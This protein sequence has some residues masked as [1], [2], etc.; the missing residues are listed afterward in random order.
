AS[1]LSG[2]VRHRGTGLSLDQE[3]CGDCPRGWEQ[4]ER[5]VALA[6]LTVV[7]LLVYSLTQRQVRL[8]L[9]VQDQQVPG[10]KGATA[11]PRRVPEIVHARSR[12][13]FLTRWGLHP[14]LSLGAPGCN[15]ERL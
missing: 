15:G 5:I 9:R 3:S 13:S 2:T 1:G 7:G 4:P 6:M 10:N 11:P 8:Y 14:A 12:M